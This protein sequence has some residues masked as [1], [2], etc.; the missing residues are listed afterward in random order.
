MPLQT[1]IFF[2]VM[3]MNLCELFLLFP[4]N[5][6]NIQLAN[7]KQ[8]GEILDCRQDFFRETNSSDCIP[9]CFTWDQL[10]RMVSIAVDVVTIIAAAIGFFSSIAVI[11]VPIVRHKSMLVVLSR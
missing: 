5:N 9:N 3:I 2:T 1:E 6:R 7:L 8:S 4:E 10:G 11:I